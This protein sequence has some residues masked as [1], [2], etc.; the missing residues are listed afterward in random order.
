MPGLQ[1]VLQS[2]RPAHE[3]NGATAGER[4]GTGGDHA[5]VARQK[6]IWGVFKFILNGRSFSRYVAL[7]KMVALKVY[8]LEPS[9][10]IGLGG[11]MLRAKR[12]DAIFVQSSPGG[13]C[14]KDV[15]SETGI[16]R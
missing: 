6:V 9:G 3:N 5:V 14:K 13:R 16:R 15:A 8:C 4:S 2:H 11:K 12:V 10:F 1:T 7:S